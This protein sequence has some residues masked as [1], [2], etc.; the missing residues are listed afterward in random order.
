LALALI[1]S[2]GLKLKKLKLE[3]SCLLLPS[4]CSSLNHK[5]WTGLKK[6]GIHKHSSLFFVS[7]AE[8]KRLPAFTAGRHAGF[9]VAPIQIDASRQSPETGSA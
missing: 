6:L 7:D 2:I 4:L 8:K 1:A 3:I 5:Y 9:K